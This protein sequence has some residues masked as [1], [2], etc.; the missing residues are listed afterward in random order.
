MPITANKSCFPVCG[1]CFTI[2]L[3]Q[4]K[5]ILSIQYSPVLVPS[6]WL[7]ALGA[8]LAAIGTPC[9]SASLSLLTMR[10]SNRPLQSYASV[11]L[12][13]LAPNVCFHHVN[14]KLQEMSFPYTLLTQQY[15]VASF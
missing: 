12:L 2:H 14:L 13:S 3:T 8:V 11:F 4:M 10:P 6:I 9:L 15:A 7:S 1:T 5:K